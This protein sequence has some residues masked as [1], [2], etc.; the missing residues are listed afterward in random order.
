M[1]ATLLSE[2]TS[3]TL[4]DLESSRTARSTLISVDTVPPGET[5]GK[6]M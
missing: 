3:S 2:L 6:A 1:R 5:A 4:R